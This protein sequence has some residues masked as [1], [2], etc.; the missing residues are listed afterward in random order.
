MRTQKLQNKDN[1]SQISTLICDVY[2]LSRRQ[3]KTRSHF[4]MLKLNK[5]EKQTIRPA[6]EVYDV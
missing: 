1:Y 5:L 3:N 2:L 6:A 4:I